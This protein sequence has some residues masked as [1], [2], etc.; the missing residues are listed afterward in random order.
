MVDERLHYL[1]MRRCFELAQRGL[2][3]TAPNPLVGCVIVQQNRIIG[4]G[5]HQKYGGPHAEVAAVAS[6]GLSRIPS[7]AVVYVNLEPCAHFGKTPP[8]ANMLVELGAKYV[9]TAMQDPFPAVQGKGLQILR[10]AGVFVVTDVLS[11][12]AR[13]LNRRFLCAVTQKRPW[14]ILKW[15]ETADGFMA[16]LQAHR[17]QISGA[18]AQILL[19]QWR[20]EEG[21]FLIGRKTAQSDRAFLTN[22]FFGSRQ[23]LRI[24][25]DPQLALN[26][27]LPLFNPQAK[28]WI[29]NEHKSHEDGHLRWVAYGSDFFEVLFAQLQEAGIQ[30]LVVEGGPETLQRFI[31][32]GYVDEVRIIRS[33]K[34][35]W[36]N[37]IPAPVVHGTLKESMQLKE[38]E[39]LTFAI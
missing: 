14:V 6:S 24:V 27:D 4:E 33:K 22:R 16:D 5:W 30:S 17:R 28:T 8:C 15:A 1:W 38:D 20:S 36:G 25:A 35:Y 37:G 12:E 7:D 10:E 31:A 39:V 23:P 32:A 21:A 26:P 18:A 13:W 2:G 29:L 19:H 34:Q 9:V 3:T 11:E